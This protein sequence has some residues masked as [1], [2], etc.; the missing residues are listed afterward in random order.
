MVKKTGETVKKTGET[1][2]KTKVSFKKTDEVRTFEVARV[3]VP[4]INGKPIYFKGDDVSG[5]SLGMRVFELFRRECGTVSHQIDSFN[6]F[7]MHGLKTLL[8]TL[9]VTIRAEDGTVEMYFRDPLVSKPGR[10]ESGQ[11]HETSPSECRQSGLTYMSTVTATAIIQKTVNGVVDTI[12]VNNQTLF[13]LPVMVRS[14]YCNTQTKEDKNECKHD[15]GGYF[16]VH[17]I[18]RVIIAQEKVGMGLCLVF[19]SS[20]TNI[21]M[22]CELRSRTEN[23]NTQKV[24]I[25]Y[26]YRDGLILRVKAEGLKNTVPICVLL[27]ALGLKMDR[28]VDFLNSFKW[29]DKLGVD[30]SYELSVLMESNMI[31]ALEEPLENYLEDNWTVD[32][33]LT[34]FMPHIIGKYED[35]GVELWRMTHTLCC[36][37]LGVTDFSDRDNASN[38]RLETAGPLMYQIISRYLRHMCSNIT[39]HYM[40]GGKN[41]KQKLPTTVHRVD[42]ISR[43]EHEAITRNIIRAMSTGDW[44]TGSESAVGVGVCQPRSV[45]G[46]PATANMRVVSVP[47]NKGGKQTKQRELHQSNLGIKCPS[48][49]PEGKS[50]GLVT[51]LALTAKVTLEE[52]YHPILTHLEAYLGKYVIDHDII[53]VNGS[54][55]G[56][57]ANGKELYESLRELKLKSI[58]SPYTCVFYNPVLREIEIRTSQGRVM[59]PLFVVEDGQLL[60]DEKTVNDFLKEGESI[61]ALVRT[62]MVEF[63]DAAEQEYYLIAQTPAEVTDDTT[64][65]EIHAALILGVSAS[66]IPLPDH[67]QSPRNVYQSAMC[68]QAAGMNSTAYL[69]R[70]DNAQHITFGQR[71]L[72]SSDVMSILGGDK[73]PAGY[74]VNIAIMNYTGYNQEDSLIFCKEA[75]ERGLFRSVIR[76]CY[77]KRNKTA[78]RYKPDGKCDNPMKH[79]YSY[80]DE[81]GLPAVGTRL[82][83]GDIIIGE[84]E[85]SNCIRIRCIPEQT[86]IVDQVIMTTNP[87]DGIVAKVITREVR[88]PIVGDKFAARHG[89]KGVIGRIMDQVDMPF[90]PVTGMVPD[91]IL[92]PQAIPSRM[93]I[94]MLIEAVL[95]KL[96]LI[97]GEF[98]NGTAFDAFHPSISKS[99]LEDIQNRLHSHGRQREGEVRLINGMTGEMLSGTVFA[100]PVHYQR[101]KHMVLDKIQG[102]SRGPLTALTRQPVEGRSRDGGLRIGEMERD[103]FLGSGAAKLVLDRFKNMSD[104]FKVDLCSKCGIIGTVVQETTYHVC[105]RCKEGHENPECKKCRVV[106]HDVCKLCGKTK[107][108]NVSFTYAYKLLSQELTAMGICS[109]FMTEEPKNKK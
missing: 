8:S 55:V 14:L 1:V 29:I 41:S 7:V 31:E 94:A 49:T 86:I 44:S 95:G 54:P 53:L 83:N 12:T 37:Y 78:P 88:K 51:N 71:P 5:M 47:T 9:C 89:Q 57:V 11:F 42:P 6:D 74:N 98:G 28:L 96:C 103:C 22:Q 102:R 90:D 76:H 48:E 58:I 109:H 16:I 10:W 33:F 17:G 91:I 79:N 61:T 3:P 24:V 23:F 65:C 21:L 18:E 68:K 75:L 32:R 73:L 30:K 101:L 59:R 64:H 45:Y 26:L 85:L 35:I 4:T 60:V 27:K 97:E 99:V 69:I 81:F 80:L 108:N 100:G 19:P 62:G 36:T 34:G 63:V 25:L 70:T 93:T 84:P 40:G 46:N 39:L 2:K 77:T 106:T 50:C 66:T 67:N 87:N 105:D 52:S 72:V 92:N 15:E 82:K 56:S 20:K 38:K 13:N 104:E 107:I 43:I